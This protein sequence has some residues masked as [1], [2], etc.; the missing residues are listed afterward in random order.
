VEEKQIRALLIED[1][2]ADARLIREML[3]ESS[4]AAFNLECVDRLSSGLER[5]V[6]GGIDLILLDL[7]LPD[8]QGLD[9]FIKLFAQAPSVPIIVLTGL[10]DEA[11]AIRAVRESAQDYLVKGQV[12]SNLLVRAMHYAI[13]RKRAGEAL[14]ESEV[15]IKRILESS[16]DAITV[17]DLNGKIVECNRATLDVHGFSTKE[18]VIGKKAIDFIA[19]K[20]HKRAAENIEKTLKQGSVKNVEYTLLTKDGREFWGELSASV[21][22]DSSGKPTSFVAITKD[23]TERKRMDEALQSER[24]RLQA[25]MEGLART[26]IG[27]DIVGIDYKILFQNL[28]LRERF[29]DSVGKSCYENYMG[30]KEPCDFCPMIKAIKDNEVESVESKSSDGRNYELISAPFPNPDGSVDKVVEVVMDITERK[31]AEEEKVTLERQLHQAQKME[32]IGTLASGIAHDFNNLLG[33]ILGYASLLLSKLPTEDSNRKYLEQIEK[34]GSRAAELTNRLLGYARQ[35][36]CE[37]KPVD[38]NQMINGVMELLAASIDKS[39]DVKANLCK[40]SP[41]TKGDANQLEQVLI[42]LCVNAR[43]AMPDGGE[44]SIHSQVVHLDEGFVS[45]HLGA[46]AGDYTC[47]SVSDSGKGMDKETKAKIFEPFYTTKGQGK[48]TGL[49]LSMV[50]GI[51]KNHDGY[52]SVCSEVGKGTTFKIYLPLSQGSQ[53]QSKQW[54]EKATPGSESILV[55]DD[56]EILRDLMKNVL[57]DLGYEAML[58]SNGEEAVEVYREH[59]EE[60]DLVIVDMVMP[61]MGGKKTFEELKRIDPGVKALLASGYSKNKAVQRI[62]DLGV[63]GFLHKPFSVQEISRKVREVLKLK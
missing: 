48:G 14:R 40:E 15:K 11:L 33:G 47:I 9:T 61:K 41:L 3:A 45:Q 55:V 36:K 2:L 25:L 24:D 49:G 22:Q 60:I 7:S 37:V 50:Y 54:L 39:I 51:V 17:T 19:P 44:L 46:T 23:I 59:K 29:G 16:P 8:S 27:I 18:E 30:L 28:T 21:I 52:I 31:R 6:Q 5:L 43:D 35:G 58:A 57:G 12:D 10:E 53:I 13:E 26:G 62:L 34:A 1:N 32:A 4:G 56:E 38:I 63:K 42:N 20:D